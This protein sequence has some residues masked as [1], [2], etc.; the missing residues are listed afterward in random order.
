ML[1]SVNEPD[2]PKSPL[3]SREVIAWFESGNLSAETALRYLRQLDTRGGPDVFQSPRPSLHNAETRRKRVEAIFHELDDL[4]G[5]KDVKG[6][7][8]EIRA[9]IEVQQRRQQLGLMGSSQTLHMIFSGAPGTGKTT[10]ARIIGRLFQALDVLPKGQMLEVERAD[11]VGEYIGH[12]A[13]KTRDVIKKA[14][15]GVM[16]VDEAYSLA[17][18]GEKDFGKEAIDTLVKAMEDHR[19]EFLLILAGYPDEMAWFL[20]TNPGLLSRFPIKMHFPDYGPAE[21]MAIARSMILE[22]QYQLTSEADRQLA[23]FLTRSQGHWHTNAGNARL[24]RNIIEQGIRR[25]AVRLITGIDTTSRE[26]LMTLTW[27]DLEGGW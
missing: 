16:F 22:R 1:E 6:M 3:T 8:H 4:V 24:V 17:R 26:D 15:G 7:I 25:Q 20:A 21:L 19:D 27:A 13:Q 12:T 11:L 10:V 2:Y 5:L 14:L 23:E 9:Y 18:G